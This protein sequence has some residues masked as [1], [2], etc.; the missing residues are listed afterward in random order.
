ME[1]HRRAEARSL[2][3]HRRVA[4]RLREEPELIVAAR[5][6]LQRWIDAGSVSPAWGEAW[7][8]V[9]EGPV[10]ELCELLQ[11]NDEHARSMRQA[12]P[13]AGALHPR[14]RWRIW[15]EVEEPS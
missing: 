9:L 14:E 15:R 10:E 6:R 3:L 11:A 4:E 1:A 12:S 7:A 2:A 13:F 8:A 5:A